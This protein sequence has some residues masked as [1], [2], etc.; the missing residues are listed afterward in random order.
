MER[1]SAMVFRNFSKNVF[2]CVIG[3]LI[4]CLMPATIAVGQSLPSVDKR[5]GIVYSQVTANRYWDIT[6]FSQLFM[7]AQH[8]TMMA[9]I[10]FD[11][12][13]EDD[14][15]NITKLANYDAIVFPYSANVTQSKLSAIQSVLTQAVN[16]Y[17]VGLIASGEFMTMNESGAG[18]ADYQA[19]MNNLLGV[20]ISSWSSNVTATIRADV[21]TH[22]AMKGYTANEQ[23]LQ[24]TGF[25]F[26][27]VI[28]SSTSTVNTRLAKWVLS[29]NTEG[30]A[31]LA[32]QTGGR[33][34]FFANEQIM[35]DA[36]LLWQAIQWVVYGNDVPVGLKM[37][38]DTNILSSRTDMDQT[39]Y[40]ED[41]ESVGQPLY[42]LLSQWK[43]NYNF[44]GTLH[45]NVAP[46]ANVNNTTGLYA[47]LSLHQQYMALGHEI[48]THSW[49]HPQDTGTLTQSQ[50]EF[51]FNQSKNVIGQQLG[52]NVVGTAIPGNA[53]PLSVDQQLNQYFSYI[54][55]RYGFRGSGYGTSIGFLDPSY[56]T[57]YYNMNFKPDFT[58]LS[59]ESK[60]PAQAEQEWK[61]AYASINRHASQPICHWMWHDYGP[62]FG[63]NGDGN[64]YTV[65]L[66]ENTLA[67]FYNGGSEFAT[68]ADV[69]D[70]IKIFRDSLTSLQVTPGPTP[71]DI[72]VQVAQSNVGKF[73]LL[74]NTNQL[75]KNVDNWYAYNQKGVF[76]KKDGGT[77]NIHL[78]TTQDKLTHISSLPMRSELISVT[79]TG[80]EIEF[81]FNGQGKVTV[82][83]NAPSGAQLT[84]EG[85][86]SSS[87]V[88]DTLTLTFNQ[89]GSHT[90]RV[91]VLAANNPP[92]VSL[93]SPVNNALF[94]TPVNITLQANASDTDGS[95]AKVEFFNGAVKLGEDLISP[96]SFD[97][98]A[99]AAGNY[100]LTAKATDNLGAVNTSTAVSIVVN[101]PPSVTLTN[102]L[103]NASFTALANINFTADAADSNGTV[104]KVEFFNG[105]AKLGEDISSPYSF[106]WNNVVAGNYPLTAKA[107]DN[108]GAET[109]SDI[110]NI[111]VNAAA[112]SVNITNP[113]NNAV[114][115]NPAN[116]SIDATAS[117][118]DG[119]ITKVEFFSG[120]TLLGEDTS[121][122]YSFAWNNVVTGNYALTAKA[123]DNA[124]LFTTS[125]IINV[126]VNE[127]PTVSLTTPVNNTLFTAPATVSLEAN[128]S[129]NDGTIAK[130]EFFN[131]VNK[132]GEDT[133]APYSFDWTNVG[134]GN[135]I[136]TA[137]ATDNQGALTTSEA[138]NI[139]VNGPPAVALTNP[140]N[141]AVFLTP[142]D[143][144]LAAT[145]SDDG[146]V[147]QVEFFDGN[148]SLG[149]DATNPYSFIWSGASVGN[150]ILTAKATDNQNLSTTSSAVNI[151]VNTAPTVALTTP[152]EG[153][154]FTAPAAITIEATASDSNGTV[155][156]VEFFNGTTKLGEDVTAPYSFAWNNVSAGSYALTAKATD[157]HG[158][159]TTSNA[160]NITVNPG[161]TPPVTVTLD[162]IAAED[163]WVRESGENTNVGGFVQSAGTFGQAIRMGDGSNN[164]QIKSILS[165]D[166]SSIP[167]A[168]TILSVT[169]Q[170]TRGGDTGTN[171][172]TTHGTCYVDIKNGAF[173]NGNGLQNADFQATADAQQVATIAN[174][175]GSLTVYTVNFSNAALSQVNKVG[176]TQL[177]SYFSLDDNDNF[178][179]DYAG[180]YSGDNGTAA[181]RP[182]LIVTYQ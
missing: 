37:T 12:L 39:G 90:A 112:P 82:E 5:V 178:D 102:P 156:K 86:D 15:T 169:L 105:A 40:E 118:A 116:I 11:L 63:P 18:L 49:S 154:M 115:N 52:I 160:V 166:T 69:T 80:S 159:A 151:V 84:I 79:G 35:A 153:A 110:V 71:N 4:L 60:T 165:F 65:A 34:V 121:S 172:F 157:N 144:T 146:T 167:D 135:Y 26:P 66:Y 149:V 141:N 20:Q 64:N 134:S 107:T 171:P 152:A 45:I 177:R 91:L 126:I 85:A 119:T 21:V 24:Y 161:T 81:T 173:N 163:G 70:R 103:N 78:G 2:S 16:T 67:N 28:P 113:L 120:A 51:E 22:P 74:L 108:H 150:H 13:T 181:R 53:E 132:L 44:I 46:V 142:S 72:N 125:S 54:S 42:D 93:T 168:A 30:N 83:L 27:Q 158:S 162:S 128:A 55:G 76:L 87:R 114:F 23:V 127:F 41:V 130:V 136:L 68:Q 182:K 58:L 31:V 10:P 147:S 56:T 14:L 148:T 95:V 155:S 75:I 122:P 7:V 145:A 117:D 9:G 123:T 164:Q 138:V 109:T 6:A 137:K 17:H 43:T 88:G 8:Q 57:I 170:L 139:S 48:G 106:A 111:T 50:L 3:G 61:D 47:W 59:F 96:Y 129:D 99:V 179:A 143:I 38:R 62:T 73:E 94:T 77:Y 36:N 176:R 101:A 29:N 32:T 33:N 124:G 97:W 19:R 92:Q 174:Q 1:R 98:N 100:S 89:P 180:F 131:G 104:S 25:Y 140:I 175:G 133:S